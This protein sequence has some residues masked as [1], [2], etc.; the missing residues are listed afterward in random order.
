MHLISRSSYRPRPTLFLATTSSVKFAQ[1]SHIFRDMGIVVERG[2][3]IAG[4]PE[5]QLDYLPDATA[6]SNDAEILVSHPLRLAARFVSRWNQVPYVIEDTMLVIDCLSAHGQPVSLGLPGADTKSWW[7][8]LGVAGLLR[9]LQDA[10]RR[11]AT[12]I[13]QLGAYL[14]QHRY[15]FAT[16]ELRGSIAE[17]ARVSEVA[18]AQFPASNP[19]YFHLVFVPEGSRKTLAE[20]NAEEFSAVDYR[21]DC[22]K[23]LLEKLDKIGW[24]ESL[25]PKL[26]FGS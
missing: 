11:D 19:F 8:N 9:V 2:T 25:Q 13:C 12:F 21:R 1:Y 18:E 23:L 5:P 4:L 14:G 7:R 6:D 26:P 15:C 24:P 20:M 22:A 3:V 16:A 10:P 17:E